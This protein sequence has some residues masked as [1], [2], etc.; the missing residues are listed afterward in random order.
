[1]PLLHCNKCQHEWEGLEKSKCSWC[2]SN[3][4]VLQEETDFEKF[5]ERIYDFM[6]NIK[7]EEQYVKN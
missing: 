5:V 6:T 1:M 4:Y 7:K 3:G 2:K